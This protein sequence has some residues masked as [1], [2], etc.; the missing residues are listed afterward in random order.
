MKTTQHTGSIT[1]T[2]HTHGPLQ[3]TPG[4]DSVVGEAVDTRK[5]DSSG[6]MI[7]LEGN[8]PVTAVVRPSAAKMPRSLPT[9]KVARLD[10]GRDGFQ[11][12]NGQHDHVLVWWG[13]GTV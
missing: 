8:L 7:A 4:S 10:S 2:S 9:I 5:N 12:L 3:G 11:N 1:L 6:Q 13:K